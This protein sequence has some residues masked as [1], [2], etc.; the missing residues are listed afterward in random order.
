M[1]RGFVQ[2]PVIV[3]LA[4][5]VLVGAYYVGISASKLPRLSVSL[6]PPLPPEVPSTPSASPPSQ[7]F[8]ALECKL[9]GCNG[10]ICQDKESETRVSS[11]VIVQGFGCYKT[12]RCEKQVNG[13]CGWTQTQELQ[14]CLEKFSE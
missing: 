5:A 10:E 3:I 1:Q 12:G 8:V 4:V 7:R 6:T 2:F 13:K 9:G 14:A 11:C